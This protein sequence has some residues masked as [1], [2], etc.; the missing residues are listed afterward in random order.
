MDYEDRISIATPEGIELEVTLAG[1]GS[2]FVALLIDQCIQWGVLLAFLLALALG[3]EASGSDLGGMAGTLAGAFMVLLFFVMMFGYPVY[4]EA[5][6]AGRTP[7]KRALGLRVVDV[8][9]RPV[10]FRSSAIRN[11][12]RLV[13]SLPGVYLVGIIAVLATQRNQRLGDLAASTIVVMERTGGRSK[14]GKQPAWMQPKTLEEPSPE[15]A[16]WDVSAI[17][18]EE[19]ATVRRFLERRSSL[20][21]EARGRLAVE[22]ALRLRPK[23]VGPDPDMHPEELLLELAALKASR[24]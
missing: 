10:T 19:L 9:G 6:A 1:V 18:A 20:T 5:R 7:G 22:L 12:V 24:G 11:V 16:T 3:A 8:D 14:K 13:D 17:T 15:T 4:F 23:V 2:R 21:A